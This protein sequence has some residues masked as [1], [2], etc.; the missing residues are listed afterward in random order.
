VAEELDTLLAFE[1]RLEALTPPLRTARENANFT[2]VSGEPY[3]KVNMLRLPPENPV[4]GSGYQM[5]GIC[6]ISLFY[7]LRDGSG[8][9]LERASAT[10]AWFP[11]GLTMT[12]GSTTM[13]V[14]DTPEIGNGAPDG[15]R[16]MVP[17]RIRWFADKF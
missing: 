1:N 12:K 5:Q 7:P 15:D 17:I 13:Q 3:Q 9:A 10:R 4:Y 11:R 2:P 6:Q 14:K 16:Y 8:A